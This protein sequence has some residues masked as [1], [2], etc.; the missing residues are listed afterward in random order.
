VQVILVIEAT[1]ARYPFILE[2]THTI[3]DVKKHLLTKPASPQSPELITRI[4]SKKNPF[5]LRAPFS[6]ASIS[7]ETGAGGKSHVDVAS[8][9]LAPSKKPSSSKSEV[10]MDQ[11][12]V[13]LTQT[14]AI[15]PGSQIVMTG[16][17]YVNLQTKECFKSTFVESDP[18]TH[19]CSFWKCNTCNKNWICKDCMQTCHDG[20]QL[21]PHVMD[22]V[23]NAPCCYC[24]KTG[25]C[26]LYQ[27]K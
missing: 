16:K 27:K 4:S 25:H 18:S 1:G 2:P 8:S 10:R 22:Q 23:W 14:Y 21:T 15:F 17:P 5:V 24:F 12:H 3:R 13:P 11:K 9:S 7:S 19:T 26:K 6:Q 20:H